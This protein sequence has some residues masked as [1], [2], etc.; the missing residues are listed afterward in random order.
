MC[1]V[2]SR[3]SSR[4]CWIGTGSHIIKNLSL[5]IWDPMHCAF[6]I[7]SITWLGHHQIVDS[8]LRTSGTR[9]VITHV[10]GFV[11]WKFLCL[12]ICSI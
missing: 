10:I 5:I 11:P 2:W 6:M 8:L 12:D 9:R 1:S 4:T 7:L 3:T